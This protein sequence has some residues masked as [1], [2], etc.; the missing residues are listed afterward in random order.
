MYEK[1]GV[2]ALKTGERVEVGVVTAPDPDWCE[3]VERLL[4]HK[5]DPWNWQVSQLLRSGPGIEGYFYVL[6]RGGRPFSNVM[7]AELA[8][9]GFLGHVYTG[10]EDRRKGAMTQLMTRQM[11]HFRARGGRALFLSTGFDSPA[12]HIYRRQGFQA[13]ERGS[14]EMAYYTTAKDR[15]EAAYFARGPMQIEAVGWT[16]W[17]S[18]GALFLGEFPGA[19]RCAPV[20]LFGRS[21]T[22]GAL[23]RVIRDQK[24]RREKG[25]PPRALAL[26]Q[27]ES[28]AVVGLAM[29]D[30]HPLWPEAC[31][32]DVYCHPDYWEQAGDLLAAL[33]LPDADRCLAYADADF[34]AK[35]EVLTAAGFRV[36]ATLPSLVAAAK[37]KTCLVDV[38]VFAK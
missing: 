27:K 13:V 11:D 16:H 17:P 8:G 28:T 14:G 22:E 15:F 18:S 26:V 19:V 5:G 3:L 2:A 21:S 25:E 32:V 24:Q 37:A 30:W 12:Y 6:H 23:V 1:L 20:R 33:A 34:A 7:T 31:L 29:W 4:A 38:T 10:P 35:R 9:V 36:V